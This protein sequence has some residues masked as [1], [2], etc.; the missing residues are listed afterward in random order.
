MANGKS[1]PN[2]LVFAD[3]L[4]PMVRGSEELSEA[5]SAIAADVRMTLAV[6]SE[7]GEPIQQQRGTLTLDNYRA[8][9]PRADAQDQAAAR[10]KELGLTVVRRGR[11]GI[12]VSGPADLIRDVCGTDLVV[13]ALPRSGGLRATRSFAVEHT[14]P[15]PED[16]FLTPPSSLTL[17]ARVDAS[18]DHFVFTP[19]PVYFEPSPAVPMVDYHNV[20]AVDIGRILNVPQG[21]D[22]SGIRIGVVDTGFYGHPYYRSNNLDYRAVSTPSS[23]QADVDD[24]GHGTA[25]TYNIFATA[26]GAEVL[27]FKQSN[28]AQDAMEDA[29]DAGAQIITCSWGY[30]YEQVF[31]ILQAT[32]LD[33]IANG[34]ILLFAAGNGH[35]AWPGS[36]PG[37]LS[38]G[39][40]FSDGQG[41]LSASNYAS[42][43]MSS[44]FPGRRVPDFCGLC[45]EQPKAIYIVMPTQPGNQMDRAYG[46]A[47][48]P[49]Q[50]QTATNDGWVGASGTSSAT[51][52]IAGILALMLQKAARTGR[53]LDTEQIRAI[54]EQTAVPVTRGRNFM[55]IPAV[56]HPNTAVGWGL[57]DAAAAVA[58][59]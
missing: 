45:G 2:S 17:A 12:T 34:V 40:V 5:V 48:F 42:G 3:G 37:V 15:R 50:D 16:L 57:I 13:Q 39:G 44:V 43:F 46:G 30:N 18:I 58:A 41:E 22:G 28:P 1:I 49:D 25:I 31:P 27:G 7:S 32:L 8:F 51:P 9:A 36:E 54:L 38:I 29:A 33:L 4:E 55:G 24:H 11:F 23:P 52:Q 47:T 56:G 53:R 21:V 20:T 35:Y 10:A 26:P 6:A 19:P 59:V 14:A